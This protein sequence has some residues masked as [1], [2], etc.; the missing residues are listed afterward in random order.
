MKRI[1]RSVPALIT[2]ASSGIG[3]EFARQL[4]A[5]KHD[6]TL[7]ARRKDRLDDLAAE[8]T[9]R[10]GV[11][12]Q[13][14][15]ADLSTSEGRRPVTELLKSRSPWILVNNAGFGTS[16]PFDTLPLEREVEEV[17]LNCVAVTELAAAVMP[18]LAR[19]KAGGMIIL[20]STAAFQPMPYMATYAATKA[21]DL[22]LAEA[23]AEEVRGTNVRVMALCP[24]YTKT[25]FST[26]AKTQGKLT[27]VEGLVGHRLQMSAE[28]CVAE[29]LRAFDRGKTICVTGGINKLGAAVAPR[30]PRI[31]TRKFIAT[32]MRR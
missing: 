31:V 29:A 30:V 6:L 17:N 7:V 20:A 2:G 32:F 5:R 24:G 12:V 21:F 10:H 3:A 19:S 8:L 1:P 18:G 22:A 15:P 16:G 25:E 4:A 9:A 14:L 26:V 13:V 11:K 23:L 28:Q 27:E